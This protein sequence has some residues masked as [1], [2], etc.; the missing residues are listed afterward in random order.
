M[1][2]TKKY[3]SVGKIYEGRVRVSLNGK[4]GFIDVNGNE[5]IPL[6]YDCVGSFFCG[7]ATIRIGDCR[8]EV[9]LDGKEYFSPEDRAKL[10]RNKIHSYLKIHHG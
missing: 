5:V 8:G 9:D 2:W 3:H 6:K 7:K 1:I 4:W 10:R